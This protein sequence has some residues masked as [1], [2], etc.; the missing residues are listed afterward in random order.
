MSTLHPRRFHAVVA[1]LLIGM[2]LV[3]GCAKKPV[4]TPAPA[5][6]PPQAETPAPPPAPAPAPP[7]ETAPESSVRSEDF[8]P[9]FFDYD[10]YALRDDAKATL[11]KNAKLLRDNAKAAI[12]IE[13]HCDERGT[14][15]YN[16]AL[17][18]RRAQA[19][20]DYLVAAGIDASRIN[21][22]SYGKE[23]PFATGQDEA[24]WQQNRRAHFVVRS[25]S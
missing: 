17:G 23:R 11:D 14:V 1:P 25:S 16:Q 10:S 3:A 13:G 24:S 6:V 15:E 4:A 19:A 5:P 9:A 7:Q 22:I 12:T 2:M 8:Q 18:E 20:R 21:L